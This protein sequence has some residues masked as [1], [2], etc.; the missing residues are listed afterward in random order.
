MHR[1]PH[2]RSPGW[3]LAASL[4]AAFA[5]AYGRPVGV[6]LGNSVWRVKVAAR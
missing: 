2:R 4:A 6:A 3:P 5:Q 1:M